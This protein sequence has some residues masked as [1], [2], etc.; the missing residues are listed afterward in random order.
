[1]F[2]MTVLIL[3]SGCVNTSDTTTQPVQSTIAP[4]E[5]PLTQPHEIEINKTALSIALAN[6]TVQQ[7]L[8]NGY[9]LKSIEPGTVGI[10]TIRF[11]VVVVQFETL[12]DF[13]NVNIDV[14]N[15]SIVNIWT[16]PKR[17]PYNQENT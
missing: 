6:N 1:M 4:S 3:T 11:S 15:S 2:S 5:V 10:N 8:K 7:Y 13:V 16:L 17:T 9:I 12:D 14:K